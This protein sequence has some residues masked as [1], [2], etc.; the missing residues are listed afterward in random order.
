[1]PT[2]EERWTETH[3]PATGP[4]AAP[5]AAL[6]GLAP[7]SPTVA[8]IRAKNAARIDAR[9]VAGTLVLVA[10]DWIS[11]AFCMW[12]AWH[13][14]QGLI[15]GL[16]PSFGSLLLTPRGYIRI[17]YFLL[18]W[19][20]AFAEAGL[21]SGRVLFWEDARRS[22][23][24]CTLAVIFAALVSFATQAAFRLSRLVLA[25]TW[26]ATLFVV[27]IVR[28]QVK[29]VL[30]AFGLWRR[31]VLILGA[32]E[33]GRDVFER[34]R[35]NPVLGYKAVAFVD[36]DPAKRQAAADGLPVVG[37]LSDTP[38]FV[39]QF[40]ASEI[41]IAMPRLPRE[42][43]LAVISCCE[44][45][46]A[47]I[48]LVPDMFGLA[49]VGI[50]TEDLDGVMV[51]HMRWNLAK[52]WNPRDQARVRHR[53]RGRHVRDDR[54]V[55][56]ARRDRDQ[57]RFAGAGAVPPRAAGPQLDPVFLHQVPHDV[58]GLRAAPRRAL[59]PTAGRAG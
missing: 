46:V 48:R 24:A 12:G 31:R 41:L 27:P 28:Q 20:I 42:R 56:R 50:Q 22:L 29:R 43:L 53:R 23:R 19:T 34:V 44:G 2:P 1:M 10:A 49:T 9:I 38:R 8:R 36:D 57:A 30:A 5:P 45:S 3:A 18:P 17:L 37:P 14:R 32:G 51:L 35:R 26:L 39:Q 33:T 58:H 52:P 47:S 55:P 6:G 59:R 13:V 11:V 21:Y 16:F 25:I 54:A 40:G 7:E 4:L 15:L